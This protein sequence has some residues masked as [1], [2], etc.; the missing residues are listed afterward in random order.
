[1]VFVRSNLLGWGLYEVLT[2]AQMNQLDIN[3]TRALDG[4]DGG[5]YSPSAALQLNNELIVDSTLASGTNVTAIT[6]TGKGNETGITATGGGDNGDGVYG[7][8]THGLGEGVKG[9]S[10]GATG[11]GVYGETS[12]TAAGVGG[13]NNGSGDG[14]TGLSAFASS[15]T[16][17]EGTGVKGKSYRG[18][19]IW[20]EGEAN[21][22]ANNGRAT[23]HMVPQSSDPN[24][25]YRWDGDL[26]VNSTSDL[27]KM[28]LNS[29][30]T[31]IIHQRDIRAP[32]VLCKFKFGS[33][34]TPNPTIEKSFGISS[35]T[36]TG[37][38]VLVT[39][40][41][42]F[43]DDDYIPLVTYVGGAAYYS[44]ASIPTT[45]TVQIAILDNNGTSVNM[46][47]ASSTGMTIVIFGD[48]GV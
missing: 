42:A 33:T 3:M 22:A 31:E 21:P 7:L 23:I 43:S 8:A 35:L 47:S 27:P 26:W 44:R 6:A 36:Y 10:T 4:Y 2:S 12:N 9:V 25:S 38:N 29:Q 24:S 15:T 34:H 13:K 41:T 45:T 32:K 16:L 1:M 30:I 5:T 28:V 37:N 19:G 39:F 18:Y 46:S 11:N 48:G 14:V 40:S 20:A 17:D